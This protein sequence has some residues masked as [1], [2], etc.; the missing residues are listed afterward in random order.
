V[1][2]PKTISTFFIILCLSMSTLAYAKDEGLA[3]GAVVAWAGDV[4]VYHEGDS[5]GLGI[6]ALEGVSTN[7]LIVTTADTRAKILL[8]DDTILGIA[9]NTR[10]KIKDFL[11]SEEENV[12][13][14]LFKLLSG[15]LRVIVPRRFT[16][17]DSRF[18]IETPT[19]VAEVNSADF[20]ISVTGDGTE[21][22]AISGVVSVSNVSPSIPGEVSLTA[23]SGVNVRQAWVLQDPA[24]VPEERFE[25]L[26]DETSIPITVLIQLQASGCVGCHLETYSIMNNQKYIHPGAKRDCKRCHIRQVERV[27]EIPVETSYAAETMIFLEVNDKT[28][29]SARLKVWDKEGRQAVSSE[30]KFTPSKVDTEIINDNTPPRISNLRFAELRRG[31]FYSTVLAWETEELSTAV[32]EYG[33]TGEPVSQMSM[34][35]QYTKKHRVIVGGL[36]PERE[37]IFR[38]I[39]KDPFANTAMS[40]D[41]KLEIKNPFSEKEEELGPWP[42]VKKFKVLK[43]GEMIALRWRTN[44][45]TAAI[46]NL[47]KAVLRLGSAS[48]PHFPGFADHQFRGLHSCLSE[49]CHKGKIHR[50]RSHP[51]G[52][53]SW[54]KAI[55][56]KDL[57]LVA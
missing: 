29:Y 12:R 57:P 6:S 35:D 15:K 7:D 38:V 46:V 10:L 36:L 17:I 48:G 16:G 11:V 13:V 54:K 23:G 33:L 28:A 31:V 32:V 52:N 9:E 51:T 34:G 40:E 53:L 3:I 8:D 43:V 30:V 2:N 37:Y 4:Y 50:K 39:S 14:V 26:V 20:I 22:V 56:P 49:G 42:S 25:G 1:L 24:M 27:E 55:G 41:L 45:E 19:A 21:I 5:V 44:I 47:G 18:R